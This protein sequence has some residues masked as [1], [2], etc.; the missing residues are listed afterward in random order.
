M[1]SQPPLQVGHSYKSNALPDCDLE[2]SDAKKESYRILSERGVAAGKQF[3]RWSA[4][5][6][7]N[8]V[9]HPWQP[10]SAVGKL[11]VPVRAGSVLTRPLL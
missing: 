4:D 10:F 3:L 9:K 7:D 5:C 11:V 1:I 2:A 8:H 6:I